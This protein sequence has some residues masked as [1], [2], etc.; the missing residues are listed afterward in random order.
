MKLRKFAFIAIAALLAAAAG[1][2][3]WRATGS[4]GD[5]RREVLELVARVAQ[6]IEQKRTSQVLDCVSQD[7]RDESGNDRRELTRLAV[8]AFREREP[9]DL[10]VDVADLV[11]SGDQATLTADVEFAV[12]QPV[13]AG[14]STRLQVTAKLQR[15]R[16]GWKLVG[17]EGWE[18]ASEQF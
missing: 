1:V 7:Y 14:S 3:Y 8:A 18:G 17:A 6:G 4:G 11:I 12:G 13:S 9:F 15:E 10:V 16:S 5:A 2:Y